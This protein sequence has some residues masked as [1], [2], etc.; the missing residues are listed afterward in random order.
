M[1]GHS[2]NKTAKDLFEKDM[3]FR[4][5]V[6]TIAKRQM[7]RRREDYA[8]MSIFEAED[9]EQEIW[10]DLFESE[11]ADKKSLE[12]KVE[13]FVENFAAKSRMKREGVVESPVSQL[14]DRQRQ[15]V[16]NLFYSSDYDDP[17]K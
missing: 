17:E 4:D 5:F 15:A 14:P 12:N 9:L 3:E 16:E 13:D 8:A 11:C 10:C 1:R 7:R 6:T 2:L